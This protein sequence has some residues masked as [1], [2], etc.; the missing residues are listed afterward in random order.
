MIREKTIKHDIQALIPKVESYLRERGDVLFG[1]LF[2]SFARRKSTLLSDVDIAVYLTGTEF[3]EKRLE[4]IGDLVDIL[5]TGEVDL[6]ILNTAPVT[7]KIRILRNKRL[8]IDRAPNVRHAFESATM[9]SYID[10]SKV[11]S[12]ILEGRY[13]NG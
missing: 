12:N 1:Y 4:I 11:E 10:F 5:K 2:G 8:L 3:S 13:L 9:R 6:V 7:L